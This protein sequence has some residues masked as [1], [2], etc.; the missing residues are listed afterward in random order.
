ML[1]CMGCI[2]TTV[3]ASK[4]N[5]GPRIRLDPA[6]GALCLLARFRKGKGLHGEGRWE[7]GLERGSRVTGKDEKWAEG[8]KGR[9]EGQTTPEQT[10]WL[11]PW[12]DDSRRPRRLWR[13]WRNAHNHHYTRYIPRN[14]PQ[15]VRYNWQQVVAME[16]EKWVTTNDTTQYTQRGFW[17]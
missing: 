6:R 11:R 5:C 7:K 15:E 4:C 10:F 1:P 8:R 13:Y 14:S 3:K 12:M 2:L 17:P 16:F 9:G